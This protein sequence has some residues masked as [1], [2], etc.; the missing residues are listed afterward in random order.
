M[1]V[2]RGLSLTFA[3]G[4]L[5][6]LVNS[7]FLWAVGQLGLTAMLAVKNIVGGISTIVVV[8]WSSFLNNTPMRF[9][10]SG[11]IP[12]SGIAH[13][14]LLALADLALGVGAARLVP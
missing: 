9:G 4:A 2:P 12:A 6:G 3:A 14:S 7:V 5:G 8:V 13:A 10:V 11:I 1:S